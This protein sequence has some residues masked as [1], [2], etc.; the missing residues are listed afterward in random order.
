MIDEKYLTYKLEKESGK[1]YIIADYD[2]EKGN[3]ISVAHLIDVNHSMH[4]VLDVI[5][6][7]GNKEIIKFI[8]DKLSVPKE[9]RELEID[10]S[11]KGLRRLK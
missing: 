4:H 5:I 11:N 1:W 8:E 10:V 6:P 9:Y 3:K 7:E 2:D